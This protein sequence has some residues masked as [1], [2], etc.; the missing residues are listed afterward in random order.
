M[1]GLKKIIDYH[2]GQDTMRE[3]CSSGDLLR[4]LQQPGPA[5]RAAAAGQ[6]PAERAAAARTC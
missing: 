3:S 5:E 2:L 6:G 1:W 4:E